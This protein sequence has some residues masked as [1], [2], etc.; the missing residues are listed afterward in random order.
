MYVHIHILN[1][2]AHP[3]R[4]HLCLVL[5]IRVNCAWYISYKLSDHVFRGRSGGFLG[6]SGALRDP[7]GVSWGFGAT[8]VSLQRPWDIVAGGLWGSVGRLWRFPGGSW[9]GHWGIPGAPWSA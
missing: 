2:F 7:W 5:G 4:P 9:V 3:A 1:R 6:V 8:S